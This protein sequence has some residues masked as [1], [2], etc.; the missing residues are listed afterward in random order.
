LPILEWQQNVVE[1]FGN[2]DVPAVKNFEDA[3]EIVRYYLNHE[4]KRR[5]KVEWMRNVMLEKYSIP[6]NAD[7]IS[8]T[9]SI[10]TT[11]RQPA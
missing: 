8:N 1:I 10:G 6:N 2:A 4:D 3:P 9:L 7:F 11:A 5:E